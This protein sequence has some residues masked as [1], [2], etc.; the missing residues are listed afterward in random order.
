[1]RRSLPSYRFT[2]CSTAAASPCLQ[3]WTRA[4]SWSKV[5]SIGDFTLLV[6]V[7]R[8]DTSQGLVEH[9]PALGNEF[10]TNPMHGS[11][12]NGMHRVRF[13]FL[14]QFQNVVV[15]SAGTRIVVVAPYFIQEFVPRDYSPGIRDKK[16]EHLELHCSEAHWAVG[17]THLERQKI[18]ADLAEADDIFVFEGV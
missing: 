2:S 4:R 9:Q 16:F 8:T 6:V 18:N 14:S 7:S 5:H 12:V 15:N 10:V 11:E 1:M 13:K 3:A 17:S